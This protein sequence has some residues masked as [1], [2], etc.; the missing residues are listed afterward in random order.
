MKT[1]ALE[2]ILTQKQ[3]ANSMIPTIVFFYSV[4][5]IGVFT[6]VMRDHILPAL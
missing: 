3:S 6:V 2:V 5:V 1:E 4:K